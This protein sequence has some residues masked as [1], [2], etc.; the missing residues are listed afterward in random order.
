MK[1]NEKLRCSK[2]IHLE[3]F[4]QVLDLLQCI[5][6]LHNKLRGNLRTLGSVIT[7]IC[8]SVAKLIKCF[9]GGG[10]VG[11]VWV[12]LLWSFSD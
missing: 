6:T 10:D 12:G 5:C 9:S 8:L 11:N 3:K 1:G 2:L 7:K 4:S